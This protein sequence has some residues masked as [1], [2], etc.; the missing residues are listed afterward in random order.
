M[1][2]DVDAGPLGQHV[3]IDDWECKQLSSSKA[4]LRPPKVG[5]C[6]TARHFQVLPITFVIATLWL[7]I[8]ISRYLC[9]SDKPPG[10]SRRL[11]GVTPRSDFFQDAADVPLP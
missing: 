1:Q 9:F 5:C 6:L 2:W 8:A 10:I 7:R 3:L 4:V 11:Y